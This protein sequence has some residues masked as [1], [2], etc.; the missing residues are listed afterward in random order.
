MLCL[1]HGDPETCLLGLA[2]WFVGIRLGKRGIF[3]LDEGC[4]TWF[5]PAAATVTQSE[6]SDKGQ[7][8]VLFLIG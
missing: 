7:G 2:C 3:G 8:S 5:V 6:D 4:I 1:F